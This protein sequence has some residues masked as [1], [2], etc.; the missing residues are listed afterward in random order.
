MSDLLNFTRSIPSFA[1][2]GFTE[3]I[4]I[5]GWYLHECEAKEKFIPTDLLRCFDATHEAK[6]ANIHSL[7]LKLHQKTPPRLLKDKQG[8]RLTASA[9]EQL[10]KSIG[11]RPSA[12]ILSSQLSALVSRI[13]DPIERT[14]LNETLICFNNKAYRAAIVMAWN[15]A[16][17]H[18]CDR[19]FGAHNI[20]FNAQRQK[21]FAR[22][23]ELSKRTDFEDYKESQV[24]EI[25]RGARIFDATVCKTLT[26]K[27]GRRNSAAHPSSAVLGGISAEEMIIDL[28]TNV[29]LNPD[30]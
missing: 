23:P 10:G 2:K 19:I 29:L 9:R 30:V 20:A 22:L 16:Y 12:V 15:L 5:F 27:L 8:Y 25:C 11:A 17:S 14:F 7:I 24:I 1:T 13:T 28:V 21:V 18:I 4:E 26:E 3:K 6:P